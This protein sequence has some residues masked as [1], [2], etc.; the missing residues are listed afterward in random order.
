LNEIYVAE[1]DEQAKF[2]R[3]QNCDDM[4]GYYFSKPVPEFEFTLLLEDQQERS[5]PKSLTSRKQNL[6]AA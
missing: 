6:S 3:D 5:R 2:L 1:T 4:Q